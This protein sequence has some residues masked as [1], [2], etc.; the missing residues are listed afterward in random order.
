MR[1][2]GV[3]N[4]DGGTFKTTDMDAFAAKAVEILEAKGHTLDARIVEGKD[5]I[6]ELQ[7]AAGDA[8]ILLAGGGDGTISAAA[9]IAHKQ[10]VPLAVLPAGTM[11]LF[12]RSLQMPLGLE[13]ALEAIAGGEIRQIDIATANGRPFVHQF[14]VGIHAKLVKLRESLS[15]SSRI[16]K[17]AASTRA[18]ASALSHAPNFHAD[19]TTKTG[20]ERRSTAGIAVSNNP[21]EGPLLHADRLDAGVLGI[22]IIAP[23]TPWIV[24]KLC[25]GVLQGKWKALPEIIDREAREVTLRFP[26]KKIG[27]MAVIDGELVK[28][29]DKVELK[30]HPGELQVMMPKAAADAVPADAPEVA[31]TP[32]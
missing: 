13:P 18:F 5:L 19:V 28:L 6:A 10:G 21:L 12:A 14:A 15:Y 4:R 32:A 20:V 23:L 9:A 3:F 29:A 11:N 22:Y 26:R 1:F 16:G 8:E 30:I 17:M 24:T 31:L 7:R 27:A 25:S 2:I